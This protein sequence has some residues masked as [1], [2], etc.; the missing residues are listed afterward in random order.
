MA[1]I[2]IP[3]ELDQRLSALSKTTHRTKAHYI[4]RAIEL[5]L[6]Q[7]EE[8]LLAESAYQEH[9]S[10]GKTPIPFEDLMKKNDV[11]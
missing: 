4:K 10:S 7:N 8:Y 9:L 3:D 1:M 11:S 6:E 2:R 5:F